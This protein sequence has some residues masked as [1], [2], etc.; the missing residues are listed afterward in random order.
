V[1]Q[2]IKRIPYAGITTEKR[3][4]L[5][6]G[7]IEYCVHIAEHVDGAVAKGEYI[8]K[9]IKKKKKHVGLFKSREVKVGGNK[10][11]EEGLHDPNGGLGKAKKE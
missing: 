6:G 8:P 5:S 10:S 3:G 9:K 7:E 4:G 2:T 1:Q 11:W